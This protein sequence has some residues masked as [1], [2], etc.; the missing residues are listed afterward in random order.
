MP[1]AIDQR[2]ARVFA[3]VLLERIDRA[4]RGQRVD[5][6]VR[7][8]GAP[9]YAE[10]RYLR[11]VIPE[12]FGASRLCRG[13]TDPDGTGV[14]EIDAGEILA[15]IGHDYA[16]RLCGWVQEGESDCVLAE[17]P[18]GERLQPLLRGSWVQGSCR[19]G[20]EAGHGPRTLP[21]TQQKDCLLADRGRRCVKH[22]DD[23]ERVVRW[24]HIPT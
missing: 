17:Q 3:S 24:R 18:S 23:L 15:N 9:R 2:C 4:H 8:I 16:G 13:H 1:N 5:L 22:R 10:M 19:G 6:E 21:N 11:Q 14:A 7:T 12:F 20:Q